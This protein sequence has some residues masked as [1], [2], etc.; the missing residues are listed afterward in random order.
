M[1]T[2][3]EGAIP[4]AALNRLVDTL[5]DYVRDIPPGLKDNGEQL[6]EV[7]SALE[8]L[9]IPLVNIHN[10]LDS[11]DEHLV[12]LIDREPKEKPE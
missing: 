1:S 5:V 7:V 4:L 9:A 6:G 3:M 2:G 10:A 11:I 8:A 12:E